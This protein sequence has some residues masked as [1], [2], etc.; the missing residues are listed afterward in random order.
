MLIFNGQFL[1]CRLFKQNFYSDNRTTLK[2]LKEL[3]ISFVIFPVKFYLKTADLESLIDTCHFLFR[4]LF[5]LCL[6]FHY[7]GYAL[8]T[9][10]F[11]LFVVVIVC[12][13]QI[14]V[15]LCG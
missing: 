8:K 9:A 12:S 3:H 13:P 10:S 2:I 7:R 6:L 1:L 11:Y 15:N 14:Q 4:Y 5:Y